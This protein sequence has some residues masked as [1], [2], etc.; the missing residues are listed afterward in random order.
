[1]VPFSGRM[2]ATYLR[3]ACT[4]SLW[5]FQSGQGLLLSRRIS[6]MPIFLEQNH[7]GQ[8]GGNPSKLFLHVQKWKPIVSMETPQ[9]HWIVSS[10]K[11]LREPI[12]QDDQWIPWSLAQRRW[13]R[14]LKRRLSLG[15]VVTAK[16]PLPKRR[17][18]GNTPF[19]SDFAKLLFNW[20]CS[21]GFLALECIRSQD[22]LKFGKDSCWTVEVCML[23]SCVWAL[24]S[25]GR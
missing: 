22:P 5:H 4:S 1:M 7:E 12:G 14:T 9:V 24:A 18:R 25:Q 10:G 11:S 2:G 6:S 16:G 15:P 13:P 17:R 3:T 23:P 21:V 8:Q 20:F 19:R